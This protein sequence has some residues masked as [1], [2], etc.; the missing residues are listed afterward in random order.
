MLARQELGVSANFRALG[1]RNDVPDI[2]CYCDWFILP[3]PERPMEGFGIA[4]VEAQ[5]GGLRMLLSLGIPDDP[6]L[7]TARVRRLPLAAGADVWAQAAIE[8]FR[9][10]APSR[11]DA[12]TALKRSPMDMD[13]ALGR[14]LEIHT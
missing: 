8:L 12:L 7:P 9:Q 3:R 5:L 11:S 10:P 2:M 6:L 13:T 14:L 1:W 4:V